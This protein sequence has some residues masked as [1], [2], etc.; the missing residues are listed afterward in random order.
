MPLKFCNQM[1]HLVGK[2]SLRVSVGSIPDFD[3]LPVTHKVGAPYGDNV[4]VGEAD[5]DRGQ[6]PRHQGEV[7][8]PRITE[9]PQSVVEGEEVEDISLDG[10][11]HF[12]TFDSAR[13]ALGT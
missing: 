11:H 8:H 5:D 7:L 9:L 1:G 6:R 2:K 3:R 10:F 13:D 4:D 12:L